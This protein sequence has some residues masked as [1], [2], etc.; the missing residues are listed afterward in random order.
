MI[1]A[2]T[3]ALFI[4]HG[5]PMNAIEANRFTRA[6]AACFAALPRP[7]AILCVSAHWET[8]GTKVTAMERPR[9]IHDFG[10]FPAELFAVDYPA[11]GSLALAERIRRLVPEIA[12]D[13]TW[14]LDHGTWSVLR[15]MR[16]AADLP[17]VQLS[18][19]RR[20][21]PREHLKLARRL[22]PLR[23]EGVLVL[24][25]GNLVHNLGRILWG[26]GAHGWA[27]A[28]D[29]LLAERIS[30]GP[31]EDLLD[32]LALGPDAALALPS[33]EHYLPLLYV[34]GVRDPGEPLGFFTAEVTLGAI[35]M[36]SL[37]VGSDGGSGVP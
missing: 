11:P 26:E 36:R 30:S 14:G 34:L 13:H 29:Q 31:L 4:G 12:L 21:S 2:P 20:R 9:T 1:Q 10:G 37:K 19:D 33:L 24:G 8:D 32:P 23:Q 16:P 6:W 22:R 5:S 15:P 18:L 35:S 27:E 17:V 25:S 3:P 7:Q 28:F